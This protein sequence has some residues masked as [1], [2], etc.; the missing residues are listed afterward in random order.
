MDYLMII[1][2]TIMFSCQFVMNDG[3]RREE[4][5]DL[6]AV[7]KYV[8]YSSITGFVILLLINKLHLE[9]TWFSLITAGVF[10]AVCMAYS[11][12]GLKA[13]SYANLSVYSVFAMIGGMVLPFLYG[14]MCGEEFRLVRL[15][16][17]ILIA[18]CVAMSVN[19]GKQSKKAIKYYLAVFVLNGLVGVIA[20]FHQ[21]QPALCVDSGS[22]MLLTRVTAACF[23]LVWLLL[24]KDR[25]FS[26]K[27]KSMLYCTAYS[28]L[29]STGN[30]L[31]LIA[32]LS[33]PA[34]VQY[35]IVTGGVIIISTLISL[36][37]RDKVTKREII[38]A[39]IAF[40][41]TVFMAF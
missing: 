33:L 39:A 3:Y 4:G 25:S 18:V 5:N 16:C 13:L 37:R 17:C 27:G 6:N 2:S 36:L 30:L 22:F 15:V 11:Y 10:S 19:Q 20:K 40:L 21:S 32:L 28:V 35:P 23:S 24:K 38:A 7:L 14:L 9:V 31:L 26:I 12:C 1:A 29:D 34:S 41:A 8:L